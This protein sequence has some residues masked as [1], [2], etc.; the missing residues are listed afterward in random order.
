MPPATSPAANRPGHR[1][2]RGV[3]VDLD[4]AHDVVAGGADLHRLGRDVDVGELLELV[5]HRR[6]PAADLLGRQAGRDVEEHPAV[7]RAAPLLDLGVD[8][9]GDLVA[10]QQLGRPLVVLRVVVPAVGLLLGVGVLAAEHV[11]HVVEHEPLALGVAQHPAVAADR[12]GDEDALDRRAARPCR[13]GGTG[14]TPC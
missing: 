9:A 3:G 14:R 5:V 4:A 12:L 6:Q 7:R 2:G 10:G 11:G 8:G 1:R 13:S